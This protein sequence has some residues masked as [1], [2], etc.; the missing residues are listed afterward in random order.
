L[1]GEAVMATIATV[2]GGGE[3]HYGLTIKVEI[4]DES[5]F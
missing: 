3:Y 2:R 1:D 5:P 4:P